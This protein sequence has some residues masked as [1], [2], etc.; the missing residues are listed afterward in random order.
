[1]R[2][3]SELVGALGAGAL[4]V[5]IA[6]QLGFTGRRSLVAVA[7]VPVAVA[8]VLALP[9]L[10]EARTQLNDRRDEN[11]PLV[12]A[13]AQLKVGVDAGWA[14]EFFTWAAERIG[15]DETFHLEIGEVPDEV[16][17]GGVGVQQGAIL[18]WG[19]YQLA[20]RLAVEQSPLARDEKPG[21]GGEADWLVF[22]GFD[23]ADY[24]GPLGKVI[25]Y[26][27]EY[28]IARSDRAR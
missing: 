20:P 12:G 15:E 5:L 27:P 24:P 17:I 9:L 23:P 7:V 1:V 10:D 21:E 11:A 16:R 28:A 19:T 2:L 3:L 8:A 26:A 13:E 4:V 6:R 14:V 22:Y 25:T 18:Q